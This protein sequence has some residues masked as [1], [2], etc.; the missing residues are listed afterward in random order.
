[1]SASFKVESSTGSYGVTVEAGLLF[2]IS[3]RPERVI[4]DEFFRNNGDAWFSEDSNDPE[5]TP[6]ADAPVFLEASEATKSLDRVPAVVEQLRAFGTTRKDILCAVG[7]GTIQDLVAF[8]ASMYMRGLEW[9]YIPTT[10]LAMV[11]SCIGGKSSINVGPYKNLVSTFHPPTQIFIDPS[12]AESLPRDQFASGL[13]EAAKICFCRGP[14]SF[15]RHLSYS[16]STT[17]NT[18]AL[19]QVIINSLLAKK[20]FI[21]IDEFDKKERLLLNFGHTFGHAIEGASSY[22]IPHGIAVGLGILCSLEFQRARGI[23][24][25]NIATVADLEHHLHAMI[26]MLPGLKEQ[27]ASLDMADVLDRFASDKKH[28]G[29]SY[30]L[31]LVSATGEVVLEKIARSPESEARLRNAIENTIGMF[32]Q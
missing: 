4:A 1:M 10:V 15:A 24:F 22:G 27:L 16:P 18:E 13:I 21:E 31:I 30:T 28:G 8:V 14:E 3:W 6:I 17:M 5:P 26:R 12:L 2:N 25:R 23:D 9:I 11:D 32:S 29:G 19:E 7:G 20:H